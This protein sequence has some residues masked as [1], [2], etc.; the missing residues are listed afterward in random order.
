[1]AELTIAG[2]RTNDKNLTINGRG[3]QGANPRKLVYTSE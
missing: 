3:P 1:M 2:I